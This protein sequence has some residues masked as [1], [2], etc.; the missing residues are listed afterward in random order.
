MSVSLRPEVGAPEAA[1]QARI[2]L[3]AAH[4]LAVMDDLHEG[5]WNHFSRRLPGDPRRFLITPPSVHWSQ[6][7]A[8]S[9]VE[10]GP[11]DQATVEAE[12]GLAWVA[13][14]IHAPILWA[15]PD[16]EAVLHAHA[17][18]LLALSMLEDAELPPAEQNALDF[19][20]RIAYTEVYDGEFDQD[21]RHG[22]AL[23][24]ALGDADVL[25]L[26]NHGTIVVGRTLAEAYTDLYSLERAAK[27]L[28]LALSTQRPLRLVPVEVAEQLMADNDDLGFKVAHFEAM[29]R[30]LDAREPDYAS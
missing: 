19:Q 4:R 23:A 12:G 18:H 27:A 17:P 16:V 26:R 29:K 20:G 28:I 5:T 7:T 8:S 6:V 13:Y 15:R 22:E 11:E 25:V 3:A 30:V 10:H 21:I 2:D 24:K 14:R 9:L 1:V